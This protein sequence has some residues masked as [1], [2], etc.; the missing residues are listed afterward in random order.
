MTLDDT[1]LRSRRALLVG[2]LGGL[3]ALVAQA[4]GR[5]AAVA[6]HDP[7]DVRLGVINHAL[8][9]T[10]IFSDAMD[11]NGF[12][13]LGTGSGYGVHGQSDSAAGV[14]GLSGSGSGVF[15]L[16]GSANGVSATSNSEIAS[17]V[18][19]ENTSLGYGVAGRTGSAQRAAT[20][21]D[22][23]GSGPGVLGVSSS[24][25]GV[26]G[27]SHGAGAVGVDGRSDLGRGGQFQ[28]KKAQIKLVPSTASSHPASGAAGDLF[29]DKSKRLW[30]CKG[31]TT[32]ALIA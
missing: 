7:D 9:V 32:W 14:F 25:T 23:T 22:N 26:A 4:L 8:G 10:G 16:S 21:G 12:F 13:G 3:A 31:R 19:G 29:L 11:G 18:Y 1:D 6:A 27:L 24:G 5:P 30:L 15:G 28:G 20:L 2:S 17:G